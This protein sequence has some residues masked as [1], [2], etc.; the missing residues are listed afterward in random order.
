LG[1]DSFLA[2]WRDKEDYLDILNLVIVAILIALTAFF[3]AAE[4]AIVKVRSSRIDQLIEEGKSGA[5]SARI[6]TTN[7]DEYLSAC[8]LGITITALGLGWLGE[9]TVEG[10]LH[11]LFEEFN[12]PSSV[13]QILSFGIAFA[14]ITFIHVVVG[15]LAPKTLAIQKAE[16]VTLLTA[17]PLILFYK[18]LYPFIWVLNNSA[19]MVIRMFGLKPA[20]EHEL[21]HSEE[22][23]RIILSESYK[24]GE[25]NQS[26]FKYVNKIF[27]FDDRIAKEIMVP[28]TEI[29]TLSKNDT[30]ETFLSIVKEEKF[31]RYPIIDGDKDHV[32]GMINVKEL[33]TDMLTVKNF[34]ALPIE[35]YIRPIIRIIDTVPIHDLLLKMQKERI[36]MAILMDEYGGTS[37]LVTVEDILEEIVG[38]I[39][40]E[41]DLDEVAEIRKIKDNHYIIDA[42]VLISQ[43]NDL[44]GTEIDDEDID[45]IGGWIL[46]ENYEAKQGDVITHGPYCFKIKDMEEHHIR[47]V[48]VT[49][50]AEEFSETKALPITEKTEIVS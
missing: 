46:T 8:Q 36:H 9:S 3:V 11:P 2:K 13:S 5:V 24:S 19:R 7:L 39:R 25:I 20:S 50:L 35:P 42:K 48:E 28:R 6:V 12:I 32:I 15:E 22:E 21:A 41:F 16:K 14:I 44:L 34:A 31:T 37:G 26:E 4:F 49:K 23:L 45:T 38:E 33:F 1:G 29:V 10:L 17:K 40:D 27:E 47:Y 18:I 30:M 43:V